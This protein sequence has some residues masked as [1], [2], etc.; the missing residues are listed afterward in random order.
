VLRFAQQAVW[1]DTPVI[2]LVTEDALA[3][4]ETPTGA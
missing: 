4:E 2:D 3:D 1:R